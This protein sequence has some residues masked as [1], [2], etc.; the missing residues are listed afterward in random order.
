V[1]FRLYRDGDF[2]LMLEAANESARADSDDRVFTLDTF[3]TNYAADKS[4]D[5]KADILLAEARGDLIGFVRG[6]W[7]QQQDGSVL[8][9][10]YGYL[11]PAWRR[12][13]IGGAMLRY[14]QH[15]LA[16]IGDQR[17]HGLPRLYQAYVWDTEISTQRMLENAGYQPSEYFALMCRPDLENIPDLPLP[18]GIE[19]RPVE[20]EHYPAIF[21]SESEA[22]RDHI[23]V[24][25]IS[26]EWFLA[27][28]ET[29]DN[30]LWRIAWSGDK[31]V[32]CV[33]SFILTDENA[34]RQRLRGYT[35]SISVRKPWR[36]KGLAKTLIALNFT[37]LKERGMEEAALNVHTNNPTGAFKLYESMGFRVVKMRTAYRKPFRT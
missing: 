19:I 24:F 27:Q 5:P 10:H 21:E 31:V 14:M 2:A 18:E 22:F 30:S 17:G 23:G 12:K 20:P 11:R 13:G 6:L 3:K 36:G 16:E 37:A 9:P 26:Y 33:R 15:H 35:E 32:G 4:F 28:A 29:Q 25:S 34:L 1:T 7:L 8:Y